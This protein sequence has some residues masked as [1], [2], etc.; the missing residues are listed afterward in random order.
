M[1][2]EAHILPTIP[3]RRL[4]TA[5]DVAAATLFL[6]GPGAD[7]LNGVTIALDGGLTA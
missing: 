5:A 7:Y 1:D 4:G 2:V 6:A 3:A